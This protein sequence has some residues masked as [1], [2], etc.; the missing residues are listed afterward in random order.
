MWDIDARIREF[1]GLVAA[2]KIEIYNEFSLQHELGSYLR[3]VRSGA[4]SDVKVQF[5]RPYSDFDIKNRLVKKEIDIVL[6]ASDRSA[7]AAI[8]LKY[9]RRGQYPEQMFKACQ[10][11]RFLEEL[12]AG[13]FDAGYFVMVADH[14]L[15]Y[16]SGRKDGIYQ[17]FRSG[18]PLS[19]KIQKPTGMKDK[20][21]GMKDAEVTLQGC[22]LIEWNAISGNGKFALLRVGNSLV[23]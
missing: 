1:F 7:K 20:T 18:Y 8:E 16:E 4:T 12:C 19:G 5:E 3:S 10:D 23:G 15:F 11:I 21:I 17:H 22:Y 13:G 14:P 6:I 9:P 2:D